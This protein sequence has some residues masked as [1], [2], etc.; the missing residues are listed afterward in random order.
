MF[1]YFRMLLVL[2]VFIIGTCICSAQNEI[3]TPVKNELASLVKKWNEYHTLDKAIYLNEIF[4]EKVLFYGKEMDKKD[5]IEAKIIFFR[6]N[7]DFKQM[8]PGEILITRISNEEYKCNFIKAVTLKKKTREYPSYLIFKND[9]KSFLITAESDSITDK[10]IS[11]KAKNIEIPDEAISGDFNGDGK[12]DK[13]WII[14]PE[15]TDDMNCKGECACK[16]LFSDSKIPVL[17][18]DQ[19]ID[20]I[21]QNAGDLNED[22]KDEILFIPDWF[23]SCWKG[24]NLF[25]LMDGKWIKAIESFSV[26]CNQLESDI[27]FVKKDPKI[28]G[29]V[30]ITYSLLTDDDIIAK[31][32]SVK[33]IKG[34]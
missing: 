25:T 26:H 19:S 1:K 2:A 14:R 16:I 5:C 6:K 18:I 10:N 11:K 24:A 23:T 4:N 17:K 7:P 9:G 13:M 30:I 22:G 29:N 15:T 8:V 20:G 33:I 27:I 3:N 21:L 12:P 28:K 32:K 34:R 31:E